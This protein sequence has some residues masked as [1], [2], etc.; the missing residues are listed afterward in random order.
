MHGPRPTT[1]HLDKIVRRHRAMANLSVDK[2]ALGA[3]ETVVQQV[4][5]RLADP[6]NLTDE[7][8]QAVLHAAARIRAD[9]RQ[10]R[11]LHQPS[12]Q[13][14]A[15]PAVNKLNAGRDRLGESMK[16]IFDLG[17]PSD[18]ESRIFDSRLTKIEGLVS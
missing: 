16:I 13:D 6:T 10:V 12:C 4:K 9:A 15:V 5:D 1:A 7:E 3:A 14:Q 8:E 18:A 2:G 11:T 17:P